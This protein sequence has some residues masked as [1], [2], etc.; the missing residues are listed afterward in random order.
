MK[1]FTVLPPSKSGLGKPRCGWL[2]W[3]RRLLAAAAAFLALAQPAA[4]AYVFAPQY[5]G[6]FAAGAG[7]DAEFYRIRNDWRGSTV[8]W[9]DPNPIGTYGYGT[10]LWGEADWRAVQQAA[11]GQPGTLA[12][13]DIVQR[14]AGLQ[15][16]INHGNSIYNQCYSSTWGEAALVPFFLPV[17]FA[18]RCDPDAGDPSQQNW[19]ARYS[20]FIRISEPGVYNFSVL[21]DDGFFLRLVGADERGAD[22]ELVIGRNFLNPRDRIGFGENLSLDEGLYGFELGAWNRLGAGIVDLRWSRGCA[23]AAVVDCAWELLPTANLLSA[24]QVP[25]PPAAALVLLALLACGLANPRRLPR[26][27]RSRCSH[28]G[29]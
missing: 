23:S 4:A 14:F 22:T 26:W 24:S 17:A 10:G 27:R 19:T 18:G 9:K 20:G 15:T 6:G 8:V 21:H 13:T 7:V 11:V 28:P 5:A 3:S 1:S 25:E 29:A 12:D 16:T 2:A